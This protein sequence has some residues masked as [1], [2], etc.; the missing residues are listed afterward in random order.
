MTAAEPALPAPELIRTVDGINLALRRIGPENGP[1]VILTH[2]TFSNHR[3]CLGL[4]N[5]L[6]AQGFACWL[7]DWRGHGDSERNDFLHSFD[8]V[9]EYDVPAILDA[10]R[11]RSGQAAPA[12]I[13]H[14]GGGLIASMWAARNPR[15]AERRLRAMVLLGSQATAAGTSLRHRLS[16]QAFD[17]VLRWQR[18]A[19]SRPKNVG[20]EAESARLMRQWCQWNL[21]RRFDSLDGF[22]YLAGLAGIAIPVLGLA[23]SGD[24]FIAPQAGCRALVEAFATPQAQW[25]LCGQANGFREDYSHNRLLLSRNASLEIWPRIAQWLASN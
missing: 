25:L 13:G 10:V 22:D 16:I 9:A 24:R 7:F 8:D 19:P 6:G 14:S 11:Q 20:P 3:S 5:Y 12:W 23:G 18:I 21:R 17:W 4:A 15:L 2:G 1:P